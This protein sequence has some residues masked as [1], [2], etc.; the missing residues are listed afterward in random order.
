MIIVKTPLRVSFFG[1]GSDYPEWYE[2]SGN[3]G[4]VISTTIDKYLYIS[5][6]QGVYFKKKYMLS[7]SKLESV[8][9][10]SKI[11]HRAIKGA[12]KYFKLDNLE[13]HYDGDL[14]ARSGMGTSSAFVV[15]LIQ[16]ISVLKKKNITKEELFKKSIYFERNYLKETVG[17]QDQ[18]AAAYGGFNIIKIFKNKI[19]VK[20]VDQNKNSKTFSENLNKNL[21]LIFT[22]KTRIAQH[23]AK[24]FVNNISRGNRE[25]IINILD[26]VKKAKEI[27]KKNLPD[28]F[29]YLLNETWHVKKKFSPFISNS[30][31]NEIYNKGIK[32]G[33]LGGKLLGAGAGGFLL[34]YVP[35]ISRERFIHNFKNYINIPFKF[36]SFGSRIIYNNDEETF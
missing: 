10:I 21:I 19:A 13:I 30:H 16:A 7:Y 29:G 24:S 20:K 22:G 31:I 23:V 8:N 6:K 5:I 3:Y 32:C 4:E 15:G 2:L 34:F 26:H 1:G 18:I 25:N 35:K 36:S 9:L 12:I 14:P 27:I 11:Q 33:A 17:T 28:D